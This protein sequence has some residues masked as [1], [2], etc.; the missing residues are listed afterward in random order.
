MI[1]KCGVIKSPT[2]G[3]YLFVQQEGGIS[4]GYPLSDAEDIYITL[5]NS[6]ISVGVVEFLDGTENVAFEDAV[7]ND[8]NNIFVKINDY[9]FVTIQNEFGEDANI[10]QVIENGEF[11]SMLQELF[12]DNEIYEG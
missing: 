9:K 12:N 6:Q 8:F 11:E 5:T 1:Y 2:S 10:V 7:E 3:I 4:D